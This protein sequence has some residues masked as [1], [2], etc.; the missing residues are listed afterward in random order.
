MM[1]KMRMLIAA[2]AASATLGGAVGALATAATQSQASPAA[3]AAAVQ[4][5]RD[6]TA[7]EKLATIQK[8]IEAVHNDLGGTQFGPSAVHEDLRKICEG[9]APSFAICN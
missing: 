3:I 9:T 5:V 4:R 8:A 2:V 1:V 6:S 7:E